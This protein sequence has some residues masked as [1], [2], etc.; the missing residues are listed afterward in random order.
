MVRPSGR[1]ET[2]GTWH[3]G[4]H[5]IVIH[6]RPYP[7]YRPTALPSSVT[8]ADATPAGRYHVA[9]YGNEREELRGLQGR[10]QDL[11]TAGAG[12]QL[13]SEPLAIMPSHTRSGTVRQGVTRE[14]VGQPCRHAFGVD[15]L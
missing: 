2:R 14:E 9:H 7:C 15:E 8:P 5:R 11:A 10:R 13:L 3:Q 1:G 6:R 12:L 4:F